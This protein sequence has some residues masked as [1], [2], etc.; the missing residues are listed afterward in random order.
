MNTIAFFIGPLAVHWY[1]LI[2][3][4]AISASISVSIWQAR[5][6]GESR[7][8]VT[9]LILYCAL[10]GLVS[11]RLYYVLT[12]WPVY[13]SS[14]TE[15]FQIWHGGLAFPGAFL[16][17]IATISVYSYINKLPFWRFVD[18]LTPGFA[19]A[20][21]IGQ[22]G[23]FIN[24]EAFGYPTNARLGIYI[25]FAYRPHGFEQYDFF[26]PTF[27]YES[28]LAFLIFFIAIIR[29][30]YCLKKPH[31]VEGGT[32][33]LYVFAFA[34]GRFFIETLR[35]DSEIFYGIRLGH[36]F[37]LSLIVSA[38]LLWLSRQGFT[39]QKKKL[40]GG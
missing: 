38:P 5:L 3:A 35:I 11:A 17:I 27:L 15:W 10:A 22:W 26:H 21:A 30:I 34:F 19:I 9:Y 24:Q 1:G 18:I 28:G 12:N 4:F 36:V 29:N 31:F 32:F 23:N 14:P 40:N 2:L 33:L 20:Q 8:L 16:G 6:F 39:I 37:C 7:R 13:R 25:D